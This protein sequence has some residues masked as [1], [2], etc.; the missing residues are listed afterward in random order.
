[1]NASRGLRSFDRR[2]FRFPHED[3]YERRIMP[4]N[5]RPQLELIMNYH[6]RSDNDDEDEDFHSAVDDED[7]QH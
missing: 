4:S 3:E 7:D 2:L 5:R 1:M 6:H